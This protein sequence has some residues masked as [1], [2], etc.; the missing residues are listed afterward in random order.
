MENIFIVF[1]DYFQF[2]CMRVNKNVKTLGVFLLFSFAILFLNLPKT[3][4]I[5]DGVSMDSDSILLY[6]DRP[7]NVP[8][9]IT[10]I[11]EESV[12]DIQPEDD[13]VAP[14]ESVVDIQPEDDAVAP[15]ES[16]VDIQ[17]EDDTVTAGIT[18]TPLT[19]ASR[20][21]TIIGTPF[22]DLIDGVSAS[23]NI[24]G[25]TGNDVVFGNGGDDNIQGA[26]SD[27]IIYGEK[28]EDV[29]MGGDGSDYLSGGGGNDQIFGGDQDDTLRGGKGA[30]F[31]SCGIGFD[32][33]V[34]YDAKNGDKSANDCEVVDIVSH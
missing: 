14:E 26:S 11:P 10:L 34:D 18:G 6:S 31:F 21:N 29:L 15:E 4:A 28:G 30:N 27:D 24:N 22:D 1:I 33:V 5:E 17:P 8:N 23:E 9:E 13:A 3:F 2:S 16:V 20:A 32:V 25:L 7:L 12:V 19:A